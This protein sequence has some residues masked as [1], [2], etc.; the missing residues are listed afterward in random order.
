MMTLSW[1]L[2]QCVDNAEMMEIGQGGEV[3]DDDDDRKKMVLRDVTIF[4]WNDIH[5]LN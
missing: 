2:E 1:W 3:E 4:K 5:L